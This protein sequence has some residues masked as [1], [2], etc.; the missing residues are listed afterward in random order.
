MRIK[1]EAPS[2]YIFETTITVRVTD[3]NYADHL[4]NDRLLTYAHQAR[5]ELFASW[6]QEELKFGGV[7]IIMTDA[8]LVFLAEGHLNDVL[9]IEVG[10]TDIS[11]V[12]FDLIYRLM[13][14]KTQKEVAM[15][16]TGI[17]CYDYDRKKVVAIPEVILPYLKQ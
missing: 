10:L 1:I 12:G 13:N 6:G 2:Q 16:K 4:S 9:K 11:K 3:L 14:I 17:I 7:G 15:I 8:A 5:V